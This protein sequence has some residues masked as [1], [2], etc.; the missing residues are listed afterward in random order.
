MRKTF[1]AWAMSCLGVLSLLAADGTWTGA[2]DGAWSAAAN[3]QGGTV[4]SGAGSSAYLSNLAG[5]IR[6]T[7]DVAGLKLKALV[8][9][10]GAYTLY[11]QPLTLE[12][13]LLNSISVSNGALVVGHT[14][15]LS[16][17]VQVVVETAASLTTTGLIDYWGLTN[18][19][20][21]KG[22]G[23]WVF[24]GRCAET[25]AN[26]FF[27]V[28]GGTVR[29]AAG[30]VFTK[31]GGNREN[32]RVGYG[33][34]PGR[35]VVESG[36]T[37]NIDGFVLGHDTSNAKGALLVDGG[38]LTANTM[39]TS[40]PI[41]V[42]RYAVGSLSV[43]NA[44]SVDIVNWLGLGAFN[45]GEL[46]V[47]GNSTVSVGRLAFGVM[48]QESSTFVG[49]GVVTV[50]SGLLSVTN[51]FV[52]RSSG[53]AARTNLMTVGNGSAGSATLRL[54]ATVKSASNNGSA[55]LT[56]NGGTLEMIGVR[57]AGS[58]ASLTNYLFGLEQ[59]WVGR[60]GAVLDVTS[61]DVVITQL[62]A[63]DPSEL[64][65][66][67]GLTKRGAGWLTL[68]GGCT[69]EGPTV[70]QQGT[71]RL[72]GAL[73]AGATVVAP[74]AALSLADG[75]LRAFEPSALTAGQG[76]ESVIE[77]ELGAAAASD[78]LT[79]AAGS[80]L[81]TVRLALV[82][83]PGV[84]G[85]WPG[86]YVV[87][88]YAGADP[89]VSG[90]AVQVPA[91][92][93][94]SFETQSAQKR[95]VMHVTSV[96]TGNSVW[97]AP[98]SGA[99]A[100]AANWNAAPV[101]DPATQVL[102]GNA[103]G[104]AATVSLGSAATLGRLTFDT[105]YACTLSGAGL[106]FGASGTPGALSVQQGAH[107][108]RSAVSLPANLT[109]TAQP[110]A[111]VQFDGAVTGSGITVTGGGAVAV[112]NS[113]LDSVALTLDGGALSVPETATIGTAVT[114]AAAGGTVAPAAGKTATLSGALSG[115]GALTKTGASIAVLSGANSAT[116]VRTVQNGTLTLSSL[117]DGG[118]LVIGEGTL[119]YTGPNVATAKGFTI[120]TSNAKLGAAFESD[121][122]VTFNGNI[123]TDSGVFIKAGRGTLTF[124]ATG[125]NRIGTGDGSD[126]YQAVVNRGA[127]GESP[128]QGLRIFQ[129]L[130]GKVV[131]G[132]PG[133]TNIFNNT[134][135]VGGES[136]L[137]ANAE[138]AG[139]LEINGGVL[140]C[141]Y[142]TIGRGNGSAV[143]APTGV[144]SSVHIN[145]GLVQSSAGLYMGARLDQ[146]TITA[147]PLFEMNDG[148]FTGPVLFCGSA[149][150]TIRPRLLFNGGFVAITGPNSGDVR[151]AV[152]GGCTSE[153]V[154]AGGVLS[155][156]NT[157]IRIADTSAAAKGVVR[158][159]GGRLITR[160]FERLGSGVGE[161]YL[162]GGVMQNC[163]SMTLTNLSS[164]TVQ[165]GGL[166]ADVPA[167]LTLTVMQTLAHDAALGGSPDGGVIKLGNGTLSFGLSQTYTGPTVVSGGV[168]RLA[169]ALAV[170]NLTL[171]GGTTLQLTDG[172]NRP[173]TPSA[174]VAGDAN[175]NARVE[176][177][178]SADG[179]AYDVLAL[180]SG[181]AGSLTFRL[182][183]TGT[184]TLFVRPGRYP[185][186]TFSGAAPSTAGW[187]VEGLGTVASFETEGTAIY[188]RIGSGAG[189]AGSSVWTNALG[190]AWS[191]AGNWSA[192][193]ADDASA[194]VFFGNAIAAPATIT[195]GGG[196]T[197]GYLA[198]DSAVAYRWSGGAL[199]LGSA[200]S[201]AVIH[202]AQ[203]AHAVDADLAAP[204]AASV[205][206][207]AGAT[208]QVN[209]AVTG[210][211]GLSVTG[212]TL[213]LTNGPACDVPVTLD[214]VTLSL[215][216]ATVFDTPF[217]LGAGG[218]V[219]T[220]AT[221][222]TVTVTSDIA[223]AGG[224][225][226]SGS[227][228]L[229]LAGASTFAGDLTVRNGTL[230]LAAEPGSALVIGE[231]T[232]RYTGPA[233][234]FTRGY[235][236]RTTSATQAATIDTDADI[237]FNGQVKADL[238]A[239]IKFGSGTLTYAY[240]GENTLSAG[241]N[242]NYGSVN[243]NRQPYGDTPSQ[244]YRSFNVF[245]G[246][247]VLGA[248]GQTNRFASAIIIGG[249]STTNADAETA[250]SMEISDGVNLLTDYITVGRGNGSLA[251]APTGMVSTLTVNGGTTLAS[252]FWMAAMMTNMTTLTARPVFTMNAGA[253]STLNFYC[254]SLGGTPKPKIV[255][256]GGTLTVGPNDAM[257]LANSPGCETELT[258]TGGS[259]VLTNQ[260][261][262][263]AEN[264]V[265]A[266]GV[267]NLDGGRLVALNLT[268]N[269]TNGAGLVNF[270]GGTFQPSASQ[271]L[272]ALALTNRLGGAR[273]DVPAGV[274]FTLNRTLNHDA[275][276]GAAADGGLAKLGAGTL[277]VAGAQAYT[278][279]TVVSNGT[280]SV[281]GTLPAEAELIAAPEGAL[282]LA[283]PA[284][285][286][287]AAGRLS[288]GSAS[289]AEASLTLTADQARFAAGGALALSGDLFLGK[290]AVTLLARETGTAPATNGTYVV[291]ACA[292]TISGAAA[293]LRIA[294]P[295]LG[296][297]YAF[298]VVGSEVLLT[299]AAASSESGAVV[300]N[301]TTG[302]D[303]A[304]GGNW[305]TPP[306]A[307][308]AGL[309]VGFLDAITAPS[310][311]NVTDAVVAG[312]L[313]FNNASAYTLSGGGSLELAATN[314]AAV[315][316]ADL[317]VH[318]V[319]LPT[320]LDAATAVTTATNAEVW[321]TGEV[322]GS[323]S[324]TKEGAG[325]LLLSGTNT[326]TGGTEV[327]AGVAD[328]AGGSPFGTGPV[329]FNG[330]SVAGKGDGSV[331]VPNAVTVLKSIYIGAYAPLALTGDWTAT[332]DI[333][334]MKVSSNELTV[335]GAMNPSTGSKSRL[336]FREGSVRFAA[337]ANATFT[338]PTTRETIDFR[339]PAS[340]S[341]TRSITVEPGASVSTR[342]LYVGFGSSNRISVTGGSLTL[343][344]Y[345]GSPYSD[346]L[347]MGAAGLASPRVWDR[348][349][350]SGGSVYAADGYWCLMGVDKA[351]TTLDVSGGTV[352]L[353]QV[354]MGHR[355]QTDQ[356]T[357]SPSSDVI[358]RGGVLEVR[359]RLNWMGDLYGL[360]LNAVYLNGGRLRLPATFASVSNRVNQTR[361]VFNGGVLETPG[362]G[363]DAENPTNYLYGLKQAYVGAG[364]AVVDTQGRSVTLA[365]RL[366]A[367]GGAADGGV[368]KRGLGAL[369]LA[370]PPC[371]TGRI[372]VQSGTLRLPPEAGTAYPDDP[373]LR[374][375]FENG[376]QADDSPYARNA[377]TF[378][379]NTNNLNL[380]AG[381]NGNAAL[382]FNGQN[383]LYVNYVDDMVSMDAYTVSAWIYKPTFA[384]SNQS[385]T[386]FG[387]LD[388]YTPTAH[389]LLLRTTSGAFRMLMTGA[390]N[391]G[392]GQRIVEVTNALP[393]NTWTMLT[394]VVNGTNGVAMYVNGEKRTMRSSETGE[395]GPWT[396]SA[397]YGIGKS[398]YLT[399]RTSGRLCA[400]GT[401][402][403]SDTDF[404]N[405]T[406]DDVTIYRRALSEPEIALLRQAKVPYGKRVRVAA[407]TALDLAGS[408]QTLREL[409]GEGSIGNGNA[410]VSDLLNPGDAA[411]SAP[412]AVL[413]ATDSLTLG[414][415]VIYTC[416]WKPEENDLVDVWGTLRVDGAGTVDLGLTTP[417]QMP[418]AP[419]LRS[420]PVM[421]YGAIVNAA[422]FSQWKVTGIG[423]AVR[424]ATVSAANGVVTVNLDVPSG[425]LILMR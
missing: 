185:L 201:N 66:G 206:I 140:Q 110:A 62:I 85:T 227:S 166:V 56:V 363:T 404:F 70:V 13:A 157:V 376:V 275:T 47:G 165:A 40:S 287:L 178:V 395:G 232:F 403:T 123:K 129:V 180:P 19:V 335:A 332:G 68:A 32:V 268:Q 349:E 134:V 338:H 74:G 2:V 333:L 245:N 420:F 372:D 174:F 163:Q 380:V 415:N 158:L 104:M 53:V 58:G 148:V 204:S 182:Y 136:T 98:G 307:G 423:R 269:S 296:K 368:V 149:T 318:A 20:T 301:Q 73:P 350:V 377:L 305:I 386:F 16:S 193:P 375:S 3:W 224:L 396:L 154:V 43:S 99:W 142:I 281:T 248:A 347:I 317:G 51:Q 46:N 419:H 261:L 162:N 222:R 398:W 106:T 24:A 289:G 198:V 212:G 225:T 220:P 413:T 352:S 189:A 373:M 60:G 33:G 183:K 93:S 331:T 67:G 397:D 124:A 7:N 274:T 135:I 283:A 324:L 55:R 22:S 42:G 144:V 49:P 17:N 88:T 273:F 36:A 369:T 389:E 326:Y 164:A 153:T 114:L 414:T 228:F 109:V 267:L 250:A 101:S 169:A 272:S 173:F 97:I 141:G 9:Y 394:L 265:G 5:P 187:A 249:Q 194:S 384:G 400:I 39:D 278:G 111:S 195:T 117:T 270:N 239:F 371:V 137:A 295:I 247:V 226:K 159:N 399:G 105:P 410:T 131:M 177:D 242:I 425:T 240:P 1:V 409:T 365:Q 83:L 421:Y 263:L 28:L 285:A 416:N 112:S 300:W 95:V 361:L 196:V 391:K 354:S 302:G 370:A 130:N 102:F 214:G 306:G 417:A 170:T 277:V 256:N 284:A 310:T 23:E 64:R 50:G 385:L 383:A 237:T 405:G 199:T 75:Q 167:G 340:A 213:A 108:I 205:L 230:S 258:I 293:D 172:V 381:K 121:S 37:V 218:A 323:G 188:I 128:T 25:N 45:R 303:W 191:T 200:A 69:Y 251:T 80:Q 320:T 339:S 294:N 254:G 86:D 76:G 379:G 71:L 259:L 54:P 11:G 65:L 257:K 298:S 92:V 262:S 100:T 207:D 346:A 390:D 197:F 345:V 244:G 351:V 126:I 184:A 48:L 325:R 235:T 366:S 243:L 233:A 348:L 276:L 34:L 120:R 147:R 209:G 418:G 155:I 6:I 312:A 329:V 271:T 138:T 297:A 255:I 52:W 82:F 35:A 115:P 341:V 362:G 38:T 84:V 308:A 290:T 343:S 18:T 353:G 221:G 132:V 217:T 176:L 113:A 358:V 412:G 143:T 292:G 186:V 355:Y 360:R 122:D 41:L 116:G 150:G 81:G 342:C 374:L 96:A 146:T 21:K 322:K 79:L 160:G 171:A 422:N 119:K 408:A 231:G 330:G 133:Q 266:K 407:G 94:A 223:G 145:G 241:D 321:L 337:G 139:H 29:F 334:F 229:A 299:V 91:G 175:G 77:L 63:R 314:G 238:G 181:F 388:D 402:A 90:W 30:S 286:P 357:S 202:V 282:I 311:V 107:V 279:P 168:F 103:L 327:K 253:L 8:A 356:N 44:A 125:E 12:G 216:Q 192:A 219:F 378:K 364:G 59:L 215:P 309:T 316:D 27:D 190:G 328:V 208:L 393:L 15:N 392:F 344:G 89:D 280:L 264:Y 72:R 210:A 411:N 87:A 179:S 382:A 234:A 10:G 319:A 252:G 156:S 57:D 291:F 4:A 260:V 387:T 313:L 367:L 127:Y 304:E 406:M 31:R 26:A 203:G 336:E 424:A 14:V 211:G 315:I 118:D 78:S 61:N 161:L 151:L 401:T 152:D 246:K 359:Q 288:L 236:V